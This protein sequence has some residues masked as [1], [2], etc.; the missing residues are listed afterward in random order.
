MR[1]LEEGKGVE[2]LGDRLYFMLLHNL[3]ATWRY[4]AA[5][6]DIRKAASYLTVTQIKFKKDLNENQPVSLSLSKAG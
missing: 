1:G 4:E 2:V 5:L 6:T 3:R